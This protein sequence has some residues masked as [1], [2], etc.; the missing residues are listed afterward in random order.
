[1]GSL[2]QG[3]SGVA[4]LAAALI[5]FAWLPLTRVQRAPLVVAA[6]LM[7]FPTAGLEIVGVV[8]AVGTFGWVRV[9]RATA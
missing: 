5:G 6:S 7:L 8:M 2:L 4:S 3:H 9:Q 1:M